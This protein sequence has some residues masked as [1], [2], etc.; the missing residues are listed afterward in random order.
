MLSAGH[1][2]QWTQIVIAA[3]HTRIVGFNKEAVF[4]QL[5]VDI[6]RSK[7]AHYDFMLTLIF[8]LLATDASL[9]P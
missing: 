2:R 5:L 4:A 3:L 6:P 8:N 9:A 1:N 7:G